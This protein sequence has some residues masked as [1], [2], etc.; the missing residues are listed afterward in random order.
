MGLIMEVKYVLTYK[1]SY[2]LELTNAKRLC[3]DKSKEICD[4]IKFKFSELLK[5]RRSS[6]GYSMQKLSRISGVSS[7]TINDLEKGKYLPHLEVMFKV[8]YPL[9]IKYGDILRCFA[10]E[11]NAVKEENDYIKSLKKG[12]IIG[13]YST[14]EKAEKTV[15]NF[16]KAYENVTEEDFD[17]REIVWD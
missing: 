3:S 2:E 6:L 10:L 12:D 4:K 9:K 7:S 15:K 17:I 8:S 11:E 14:A 1:D 5:Q 16:V 13:V